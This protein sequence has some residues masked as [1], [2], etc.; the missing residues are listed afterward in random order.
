MVCLGNDDRFRMLIRRYSVC[1]TVGLNMKC[2]IPAD[3]PDSSPKVSKC[4]VKSQAKS[5]VLKEYVEQIALEIIK[6]LNDKQIDELNGLIGEQIDEN[7]G[8]AM[9][10]TIGK[11]PFG[12]AAIVVFARR[13]WVG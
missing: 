9:I 6:G 13:A 12:A 7:A 5:L 1:P 2:D 10:F 8:G 3:Y 11:V 4:S